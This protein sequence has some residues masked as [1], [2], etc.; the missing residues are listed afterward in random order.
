[1][2]PKRTEEDTVSMK[3]WVNAPSILSNKVRSEGISWTM[4]RH[5]AEFLIIQ[6]E[7]DLSFSG[8]KQK[9]AKYTINFV[10]KKNNTHINTR[11]VW[12]IL[13]WCIQKSERRL[14]KWQTLDVV[15]CIVT[16]TQTRI[17]TGTLSLSL[18]K[19]V[20]FLECYPFLEKER[21]GGLIPPMCLFVSLLILPWLAGKYPYVTMPCTR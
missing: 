3:Q 12:K 8:L 14:V 19:I 2:T 21:D 15:K 1:M 11:L 10:K 6:E 13:R 9:Y 17:Q 5:L 20:T 7:V 16:K 4:Q 18:Y